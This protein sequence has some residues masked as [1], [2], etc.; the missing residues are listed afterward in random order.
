VA[1]FEVMLAKIEVR[2]AHFGSRV[3]QIEAMVA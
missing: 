3:A 2:V 1:Q